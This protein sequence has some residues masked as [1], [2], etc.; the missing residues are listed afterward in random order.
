[1]PL[2]QAAQGQGAQG[3]VHLAHHFQFAPR[4]CLAQ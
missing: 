4:R 3:L 2:A 1:M